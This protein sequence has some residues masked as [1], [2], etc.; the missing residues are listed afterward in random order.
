[1]TPLVSVIIP[2]YN[3]SK[4]LVKRIESILNQS[5]QDFE[6]IILDDFSSDSSRELIESYKNNPKVSCLLF[7]NVNSGSTFKQWKKGIDLAKGEWIWVAESDDFCEDNFLSTLMRADI[8]SS[9]GM[10]FCQSY[11][12][13]TNSEVISDDIHVFKNGE[14]NGELFL[15]EHLLKLNCIPNASAVVMKK[16]ILL[17]ALTDDVINLK[18]VGDW[19]VWSKFALWTN[20]YYST[21]TVNYHRY[22]QETVRN[23]MSRKGMYY[24]EFKMFRETLKPYINASNNISLRFHLQKLNEEYYFREEGLLACDFI[25]NRRLL[26]SLKP[27]IKATFYPTFNLYYIKSAFYWFKKVYF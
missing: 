16:S 7:N 13:D 24:S 23:N 4:Y 11:P 26:K 12:I 19:L 2:N 17:R 5:F 8:S 9:C 1:M 20:I 14:W 21:N 22:H 3:H 6:I 10:R 27:I 25:K 18:L 15:K